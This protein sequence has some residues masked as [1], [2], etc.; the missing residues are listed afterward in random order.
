MEHI[1]GYQE[2]KKG[3]IAEQSAN[4]LA[5]S[6]RDKLLLESDFSQMVDVPLTEN[7]R[8]VWRKYRQELR[9]LP[10]TVGWP[11]ISAPNKPTTEEST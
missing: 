5:R 7:Q 8:E 6:Y 10:Q 2:Y 3:E 9:D 1:L 11:Y 4:E